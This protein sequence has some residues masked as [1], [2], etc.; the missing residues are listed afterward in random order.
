MLPAVFARGSREG[1]KGWGPKYEREK[2]KCLFSP[3]HRAEQLRAV[4]VSWAA[5]RRGLGAQAFV[6]SVFCTV[7]S[8]ILVFG[9]VLLFSAFHRPGG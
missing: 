9:M 5:S 3:I 8:Q 4:G 7:L 2:K 6:R 1:G